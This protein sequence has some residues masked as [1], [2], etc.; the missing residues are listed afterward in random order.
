M[1]RTV[2]ASEFKARCLALMDEV[3]ESG[4][5]LVITKHGK[6]VVRV[7]PVR[8][9]GVKFGFYSGHVEVVGDIL[10]PID[11]TWEAAE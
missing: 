2:K 7:A 4:D 10:E 11:V 3:A 1:E 8:P 5:T 9:A 6:P